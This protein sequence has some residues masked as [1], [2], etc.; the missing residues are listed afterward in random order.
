M[1]WQKKIPNP[2][3]GNPNLLYEIRFHDC[4]NIQY[5]D[6]WTI[7]DDKRLPGKCQLVKRPGILREFKNSDFLV[8]YWTDDNA[9]TM[10]DKGRIKSINLDEKLD[11]DDKP[12]SYGM[13][14]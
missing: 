6:T 2:R 14:S 11:S 7:D 13:C 1:F 10:L 12:T 4:I 3:P 9:I 5:C 8:I